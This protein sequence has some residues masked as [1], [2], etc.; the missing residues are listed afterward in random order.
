MCRQ[1]PFFRLVFHHYIVIRFRYLN[2]PGCLTAVVIAFSKTSNDSS[3]LIDRIISS[4][5][6]PVPFDSEILI[7]DIFPSKRTI[8]SSCCNWQ[9]IKAIATHKIVNIEN[10]TFKLFSLLYHQNDDLYKVSRV[11]HL[12]RWF[13][14]S[15]GVGINHKINLCIFVIGKLVKTV[16][17]AKYSW[18]V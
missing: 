6:S 18:K 10:I 13:I 1:S 16:N 11:A 14:Y 5:I 17:S 9:P 8:V 15:I 4:F 2:L 12:I 3:S 7:S